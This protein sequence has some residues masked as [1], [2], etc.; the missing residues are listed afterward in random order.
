MTIEG[1][2]LD[3][4]TSK[5]VASRLES[6]CRADLSKKVTICDLDGVEIISL[7]LSELRISSRI[8]NTPRTV[9]FPDGQQFVTENNDAIDV[10]VAGVSS[11]SGSLI[12]KLE[13]RLLIVVAACLVTLAVIWGAAVYG[14]PQFAKTLAFN[15]PQGLMASSSS[16]LELLDATFFDPSQLDKEEQQRVYNL[17]NPYIEDY[18]RRLDDDSEVVP[19][20]YFRSGVGANAFALPGGQIVFTD[21]LI[22]LVEIGRA[23]V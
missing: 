22:Q 7:D 14:V 12:H 10:L 5:R 20:L 21:D 2:F 1:Y 13:S 3:G 4:K 18:I 15:M 11:G 17:L 16:E 23:H 9:D 6:H 8:G 19:A